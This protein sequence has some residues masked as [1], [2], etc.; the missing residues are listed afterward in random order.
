MTIW[1]KRRGENVEYPS[2]WDTAGRPGAP[3][4]GQTGFNTDFDGL[5]TYNGTAWLIIFGS[6]TTAT[7][8]S[9][10]L[11]VGSQGFN[12]DTG[13]GVEIWDGTNWYM[14]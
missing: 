11:A 3:F 8:P 5:E 1:V 7:R 2:S 10:L 9:T 12:T 4:D 6:W 14:S 13:M